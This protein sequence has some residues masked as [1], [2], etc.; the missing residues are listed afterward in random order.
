M[1]EVTDGKRTGRAAGWL[2]AG[3]SVALLFGLAVLKGR[4]DASGRDLDSN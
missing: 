3:L 2:V 1:S 4:A